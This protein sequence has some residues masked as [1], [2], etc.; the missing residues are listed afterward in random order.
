MVDYAILMAVRHWPDV[1]ERAIKS[2]RQFSDAPIVLVDDASPDKRSQTG[3][4]HLLTK[5]HLFGR[6]SDRRLQHGLSLDLALTLTNAPWVITCDN[7]VIVN[8][9]RA[10]TMLLEKADNDVGA[11]GRM[12]NNAACAE[13]GTYVHPH[14]AL[15][16]AKA[17]RE[18]NL[19]FAPFQLRRQNDSCIVFATAQFLSY[20]LQA[21]GGSG[22]GWSAPGEPLKL[23]PVKLDKVITHAQVWKERGESWREKVKL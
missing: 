3:Y 2:I 5:Y 7:D 16:N 15:W 1:A 6:R 8:E 18:H 10:F 14:W 20:Q 19:S 13:F 22:A 9:E 17:I 4:M 11:I 23:V 21:L 12:Y